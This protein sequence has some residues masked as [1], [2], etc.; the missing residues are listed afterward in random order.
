MMGLKEMKHPSSFMPNTKKE[1][2]TKFLSSQ[3]IVY[4]TQIVI[5]AA[6]Q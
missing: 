5:D 6:E 2:S 1:I 3:W 4:D